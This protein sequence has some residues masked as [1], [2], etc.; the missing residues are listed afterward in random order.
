MT[1]HTTFEVREVTRSHSV[2]AEALLF[3]RPSIS[4][5]VDRRVV[6]QPVRRGDA[7]SEAE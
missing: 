1:H 5:M 2:V 7:A 3:E 4:G 6:R